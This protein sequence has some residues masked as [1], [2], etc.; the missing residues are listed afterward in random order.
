MR[1]EPRILARLGLSQP[2]VMRT[3]K[4]RRQCYERGTSADPQVHW[5]SELDEPNEVST[6]EKK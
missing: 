6:L 3:K 5:M 1:E 4:N 2:N